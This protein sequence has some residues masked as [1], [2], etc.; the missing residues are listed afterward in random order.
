LF[1]VANQFNRGAA[2]LADGDKKAQ[3]TTIHLGA[4]RRAKAWAAYASTRVY[5]AAGMA[6]LDET[7][8]GSQYD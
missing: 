1:D 6:L 5:L 3:V 2:L 8:W 4:G 7:N